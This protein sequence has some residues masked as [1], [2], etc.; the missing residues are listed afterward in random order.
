M[1]A[2]RTKV[3]LGTYIAAEL[4]RYSVFD[5]QVI[6]GKARYEVDRLPT[7]YRQA[8]R[9]YLLDHMVGQHHRILSIRTTGR[10]P[11]A[12]ESISDPETFSSFCRMVPEGCS[13]D[14]GEGTYLPYYRSPNHRLFYYLLSAFEMFVLERP[15]HP[16]GMP[17]PGG[18][19]VAERGGC[20]LCPI[21]DKEKEVTFSI[22]NFCPAKQSP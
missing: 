4:S 3:D 10:F 18:L 20:Y 7:G 17:F 1:E 14:H 15:G 9:P 2:S 5:L 22:C 19:R 13:A 16:V 12:R 21:R 6:M 11:G 8:V